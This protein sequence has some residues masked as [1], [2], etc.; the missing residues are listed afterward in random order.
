MCCAA[1]K[2]IS[3]TFCLV[4]AFSSRY[5]VINWAASG[6]TVVGGTN[7][8]V[9]QPVLKIAGK[10]R[11]SGDQRFDRPS[12]AEI[13]HGLCEGIGSGISPQIAQRFGGAGTG[14]I[15]LGL[16]FC[17]LLCNL[18]IVGA[19]PETGGK[20]RLFGICDMQRPG[21]TKHT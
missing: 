9:L 15:G 20:K 10:P 18:E 2:A 5:A 6:E 13:A 17:D 7:L 11:I 14:F 3:Q 4:P 19:G 21:N 1:S 16:Q 8:R 12:I